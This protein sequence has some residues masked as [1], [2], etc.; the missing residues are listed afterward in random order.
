[1]KANID[2]DKTGHITIE[3]YPQPQ[4]GEFVGP[5][6]SLLEGEK[7]VAVVS[8]VVSSV[9]A[10]PHQIAEVKDIKAAIKIVFKRCQ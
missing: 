2:L 1:M 9:G 10:Y 6:Y 4:K 3:L 8:S 7:T 5:Y